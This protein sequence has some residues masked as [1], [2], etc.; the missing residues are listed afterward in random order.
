MITLD[1]EVPARVAPQP[2]PAE[3]PSD[4]QRAVGLGLFFVLL[5]GCFVVL[6]PFLAAI[7]WAA[8]LVVSSWPLYCRLQRLTGRPSVAALAM[9]LGLAALLLV[10]L[11]ILGA[12][13]SPNVVQVVAAVRATA[14]TG[15]PPPPPWLL[16]LPIGGKRLDALW[17]TYDIDAV[18][19]AIE[20]NLVP[21]RDWV[22]ARG[23]DLGEGMLQMALSL[24][25]AFFLYRDAPAV[26]GVVQG[27]MAKVMGTRASRLVATAKDTIN[28]V[29]RGLLGTALIQAILLGLGLAIASVPGPVFLG[30]VAFFLS[31][32]PMGLALMWLPAAGWLAAH[33]DT[34]WAIF[35]AIWGAIVGSLDN[36][37]RPFLMG[38]STGLPFLLVLLGVV[39]GALTFGLVG[40]FL[41]PIFLAIAVSLVR[42]WSVGYSNGES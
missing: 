35:I 8:I 10:P 18:R 23:A 7:L 34:G 12:R 26:L 2:P 20:S 19:A 6:R 40:L 25:T 3:R 38:K 32:I 24:L 28:A 31:L 1:A 4:I 30:F 17:R 15:L 36:V 42:E 9:T 5:A 27:A 21:I 29:V 39:G 33:G 11:L 22:L 41:G 16:D 14:E 13:L 37:T